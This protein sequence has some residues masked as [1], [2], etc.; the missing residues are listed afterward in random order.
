MFTRQKYKETKDIKTSWEDGIENPVGMIKLDGANYF[1]KF[2]DK[3]SPSYISRRQSVT[4]A[5]LDKTNRVPHL[6]DFSLPEFANEIYNVEL[7]HTGKHKHDDLESHPIASGIMNSLPARALETQKEQ[8]PIRA[9]VFD[10]IEP[11]LPTYGDKI[12]RIHQLVK[13]VNKPSIIFL[14]QVKIGKEAIKDLITSTRDTG[15]EGVVITS[16]TTP[17]SRNFRLKIKHYQTWNLMVTG[18]TEEIDKNGVP[19]NSLGALI[20]SD[21]SGKEVANVGTGF[22]PKMRDDIWKHRR[23]DRQVNTSESNETH[24]LQTE[25]A[26]V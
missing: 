17:E 21:A 3:G 23:V 1:L 12:K 16:L 19:K 10:V 4:G 24:C 25:D 20:V 11:R 5:W 7:H 6:A 2:D 15:R 18:V 9:A 13:A 8:G 22:T 14:P 26:C